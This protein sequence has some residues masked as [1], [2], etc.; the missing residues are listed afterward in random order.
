MPPFARSE[1]DLLRQPQLAS[2][3]PAR[4]QDAGLRT[5]GGPRLPRARQHHHAVRRRIECARLRDRLF[6]TAARGRDR[7]NAAHLRRPAGELRTDRRGVH[8]RQRHAGRHRD[9][10]H[11]RRGH[12]DRAADPPGRGAR[13]AA[14]DARR[15]G[16]AER[17]GDRR[18]DARSRAHRHLC[19]AD[20]GP[21]GCRIR[22]A[23][24]RRHDHAGADHGAGADRQRPEGDAADRR[25]AGSGRCERHPASRCLASPSN[26]TA[27]PRSP[28]RPT[29]PPHADARRGDGDRRALRRTAHA[30]RTP[31]LHRRHG[32]R[33]RLGAGADPAGDGGTER[34]GGAGVLRP[35]D[36]GMGPGPA[37]RRAASTASIACCTAPASR[38][39]TT[40][41]K[42]P[43]SRLVRRIVGPRRAGGRQLR[44]ARQ[45]LGRQCRAGERLYRLPHQPASRHARA[46][47][48]VGADDAPAAVG[49][50]DLI[51]R[52]S[53]CRSCRR[54]SAC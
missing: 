10:T 4:H 35:H 5:V 50:E 52:A 40:T 18:R 1:T 53:A 20:I 9:P 25:T 21:G 15:R 43:S 7:R 33:R 48:R 51:L 30:G 39:R 19:R 31:R 6:R 46:R 3:L 12:R 11:H 37:R 22:Q 32:R 47:R 41:P 13:R 34:P 54:P 8:G 24:R 27:S 44:P 26:A 45:R 2:V 28:P 14:R 38:P 23:A 16:D 17:G 42:A 29:S 36:G 49:H